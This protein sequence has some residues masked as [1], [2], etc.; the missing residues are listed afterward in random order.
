MTDEMDFVL[1]AP[2]PVLIDFWRLREQYRPLSAF[3]V[4]SF[5]SCLWIGVKIFSIVHIHVKHVLDL[6]SFGVE[7]AESVKVRDEAMR[8]ALVTLLSECEHPIELTGPFPICRKRSNGRNY[9]GVPFIH[10]HLRQAL[11]ATP[12]VDGPE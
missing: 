8:E 12:I 4:R 2:T 6:I 3:G 5:W 9:H 11:N 1:L 10:E 7:M